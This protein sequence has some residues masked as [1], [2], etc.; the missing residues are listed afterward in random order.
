[1]PVRRGATLAV[2][3]ELLFQGWVSPKER[4]VLF[5]IGNGLKYPET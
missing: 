3:K 2:L 4:V 5:S 1:M